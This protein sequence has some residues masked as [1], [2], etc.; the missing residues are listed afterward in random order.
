MTAR[1]GGSWTSV[2]GSPRRLPMHSCPRLIVFCNPFSVVHLGCE[3]D[4]ILS[5]VCPSRESPKL[6]GRRHKDYLPCQKFSHLESPKGFLPKHMETAPLCFVRGV[7]VV[8]WF[9][10]SVLHVHSVF[11]SGPCCPHTLTSRP[12]HLPQLAFRFLAFATQL[13]VPALGPACRVTHGSTFAWVLDL[14]LP[15]RS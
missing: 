14:E 15:A 7:A 10:S 2:P 6:R 13:P 9:L 3:H 5:P 12:W 11:C 4:C 8:V 1:G